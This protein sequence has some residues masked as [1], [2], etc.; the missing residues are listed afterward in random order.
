MSSRVT[1]PSNA[2]SDK[3]KNSTCKSQRS[4]EIP[5]EILEALKKPTFNV[6]LVQDQEMMTLLEHMFYSLNLVTHFKMEPP[7]LE[8]FLHS[9]QDHYRQNPF[10]NFR[11]C[12]CVTQMMYS[13]ICLCHLQ[14]LLSPEDMVTLMVA[15]LCHDVDHPGLNNNYQVNAHTE[16]ASRYQNISPLENH[17]CA[18]TMEILSRAPCN[19]FHHMDPEEA[20]KILEGITELILVTDMV[21]HPQILR[22]LQD[23]QNF[24]FSNKDHLTLLKKGLVKL[25]DLS[26]EARPAEVA[27]RWAELLMEEYF[28][29]SDREKDEGLPVT[30]YMDRDTVT[31]AESQRSFISF[32]I[33]PLC[34]ALCQIFPQMKVAMLQPL[35]E[36]NLRYER[37]IT[38]VLNSIL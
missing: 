11:H 38:E 16:L 37:Q 9:L 18:I 35:M 14:E 5:E 8:Q 36:A 34:E 2:D 4:E 33:I 17:H 15:A 25:C 24:S 21:H 1:P 23:A 7:S 12:F 22:S 19:I 32:M 3:I 6:W 20:K 10:H 27:E 29:Q 28:Q 31:K 30:P 13:M 26:N